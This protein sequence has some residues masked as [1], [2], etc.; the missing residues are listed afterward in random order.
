[1]S[2]L[3]NTVWFTGL[4][5]SGKTTLAT[6]LQGEM[7]ARGVNACVV[8]GDALRSG[9][10]QGLGFSMEDRMEAVRRAAEVAKILNGTGVH[11][12]ISMISPLRA[13]RT[14]AREIIGADRYIEVHVS[15]SLE[16]CERRDPKGLYRQARAGTLSDFTGIHSPYE[17]SISPDFEVVCDQ[18]EGEHLLIFLEQ[19]ARRALGPIRTDGIP[20]SGR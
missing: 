20:P 11:A 14:M 7:Q 13:M 1:M 8:D 10:N 12:L 4:S 16:I 15:T 9:L 17:S 2:N 19:V 6:R 5:G 18:Y 3:G